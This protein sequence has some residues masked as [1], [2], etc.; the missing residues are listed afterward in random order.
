VNHKNLLPR[1]KALK[2]Q[3]NDKRKNFTLN[4]L[5]DFYNIEG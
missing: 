3:M 4:H 1:A 5:A 2:A